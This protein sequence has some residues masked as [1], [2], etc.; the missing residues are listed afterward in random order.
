ME[1]LVKGETRT[2]GL[3]LRAAQETPPTKEVLVT[4]QGQNEEVRRS[5][6]A[7]AGPRKQK[8]EREELQTRQEGSS[9]LR[10]ETTSDRERA[11][12]PWR[13]GGVR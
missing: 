13:R 3:Q 8:M 5:R 12:A 6:G 9:W 11:A 2:G 10:E 1:K 7:R 4:R